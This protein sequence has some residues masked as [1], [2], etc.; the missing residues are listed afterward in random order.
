MRTHDR[1]VGTL[2]C[3]QVLDRLSAYLD[4]DLPPGEVRDIRS[5][6]AGC[7]GCERFGS[8]F[9]EVLAAF[10][11]EL[12]PPEPLPDQVAGRLDARLQVL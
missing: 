7:D 1:R 4:G 6:L 2:R 10:R 8:G 5:H 11:R 12:G 9:A 3:S